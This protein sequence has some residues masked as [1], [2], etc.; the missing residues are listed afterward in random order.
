MCQNDD[1]SLIKGAKPWRLLKGFVPC[2]DKTLYLQGLLEIERLVDFEEERFNKAI[3]QNRSYRR[4]RV[5]LRNVFKSPT[6]S[7][8]QFEGSSGKC[9]LFFFLVS[10]EFLTFN[11]FLTS[12]DGLHN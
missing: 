7:R 12:T 4:H 8:K 5:M 6:E 9:P 3:Q 10:F 2:T 1:E 11:R